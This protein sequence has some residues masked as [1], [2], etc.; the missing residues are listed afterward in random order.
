LKNRD[1]ISIVEYNHINPYLLIMLRF[2]KDQGI[3][4]LNP[5]SPF[6]SGI[7]LVLIFPRFDLGFLAWISLV[8]L[9]LSLS[10]TSEP[11]VAFRSGIITGLIYF[12]GTLYWVVNPIYYYGH[13]PSYLSI[14]ILLGMVMTLSLY[15]GL[16][17]LS[18]HLISKRIPIPLSLLAPPLWTS[19]ELARTYLL[20]GFP[21]SGLGYS[22][23][24][25][26]PVIQIADITGVYGISFLVVAVNGAIADLFIYR[27]LKR[28]SILLGPA[29]SIT[30][31]IVALAYGFSTLKTH[32][33]GN[34]L[35]IGLIQGNI[36]QDRKWDTKYQREVF[37][38]YL[39][40]TKEALEEGP[41]II[42]WP[43]ASTPFYFGR[44]RIYTEELINFVRDNRLYLLFG[45]PRVK[46]FEGGRYYL[47]NSAYLLSPGGDV[48]GIYDKIHL[49]PFGEYVPL[50]R[51]LFFIDKL[52]EGIG[53]FSS[54]NRYEVFKI[55]EGRFGTLICYEIIF[56]G[57]VRKFVK[58]GAEFIVTI[59]NDAWFGRT[60]APYQHFSM[61]VLRAVENRVPIARAA[62][63]GISGFI[64]ANGNIL[65]MSGI[66][67]EGM[68]TG[69][70]RLS[71]RKTFYTRH[72]DI[73]AYICLGFTLLLSLLARIRSE[74]IGGKSC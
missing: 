39:R 51:V 74:K 43:E 53:D 15:I 2:K 20:S 36:E 26:L 46:S 72:G 41:D 61:A 62:N 69:D 33:L 50:K 73:F 1:D 31:F 71:T 6:L 32:H 42:V 64:D 16:F 58:R 63:T 3:N 68:Y 4:G 30:L 29:I 34:E 27:T 24:R 52:V 67:H 49:V 55:P 14:L 10:I 11:R 21:W 48:S 45:S 65:K 19:I 70:I 56:P 35:R 59:T 18:F 60:S 40:L 38:I 8:P 57:L 37:D 22:Q 5:L 23:Y 66:F 7:M 12:L 13:L 47:A 44:D 28:P 9:L 25:F 17:A 54:G